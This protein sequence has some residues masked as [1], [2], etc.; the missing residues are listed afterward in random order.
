M[1][2]SPTTNSMDPGASAET[3]GLSGLNGHTREAPLKKELSLRLKE[4]DLR[5]PICHETLRDP[6]VTQCGHSFCFQCVSTHLGFAKSCPSCRM[7]LSQEQIFPN[8]LLSTV[9]KRAMAVGVHEPLPLTSTV[10]HFLRHTSD[11]TSMRD[12]DAAIHVL[13]ER[14]RQLQKEEAASQLQLLV[15]F[16][17]YAKQQR[18]GRTAELNAQLTCLQRDIENISARCGATRNAPACAKGGTDDAPKSSSQALEALA[19]GG[20]PHGGSPAAEVRSTLP[21]RCSYIILC[22][23]FYLTVNGQI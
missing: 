18:E 5:C 22:V 8:F 6:F 4:E 14:K 9:V 11:G 10:D 2:A 7:Y 16:L 19:A 17:Q 20:S 15:L 23:L 12:L 21:R 1:E 13:S 3:S